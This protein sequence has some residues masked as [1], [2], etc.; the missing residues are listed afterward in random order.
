MTTAMITWILVVALIITISVIHLYHKLRF[1]VHHD[2]K[3]I[4]LGSDEDELYLPGDTV[5]AERDD[6]L[7]DPDQ[8]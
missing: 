1:G 6:C 5:D 7:G 2:H 4:E 3:L 8:M